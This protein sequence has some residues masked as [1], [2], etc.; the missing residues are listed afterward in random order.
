MKLHVQIWDSVDLNISSP[1]HSVYVPF[2][3]LKSSNFYN[4]LFMNEFFC[5]QLPITY[6]SFKLRNKFE[7][8]TSIYVSQ[9]WYVALM[10]TIWWQIKELMPFFWCLFLA[11][12]SWMTKPISYANHTIQKFLP[13]LPLKVMIFPT[14]VLQ[15]KLSALNY[16]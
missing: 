1:Y 10:L 15:W 9:L 3:L 12:T 6:T 16:N 2:L 11:N 7:L 4:K 8:D 14:S 13:S 5:F